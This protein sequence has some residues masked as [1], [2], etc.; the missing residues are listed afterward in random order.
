MITAPQPP[1]DPAPDRPSGEGGAAAALPV[2]SAP[3]SPE[4]LAALAAAIDFAG[5][6]LAPATLRAYRSDWQHFCAWCRGA[7]W[8]PLPA[9]PATVGAYLASL[10]A[11]HTSSN[12]EHRRLG[13]DALRRILARRT[14][15]RGRT[16][17]AA[18]E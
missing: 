7:G 8:T 3:V 6:A 15:R 4:A 9:D 18:A 1:A 14:L 17:E 5:Q 16:G 11:S 2:P 10:A 12:I 13:T